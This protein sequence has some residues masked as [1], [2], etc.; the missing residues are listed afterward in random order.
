MS[1]AM[2]VS[3]EYGERGV[4]DDDDDESGSESESVCLGQSERNTRL[5]TRVQFSP[6]ESASGSPTE[7]AEG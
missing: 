1:P 4:E 2:G 5:H 6:A 7:N 3:S